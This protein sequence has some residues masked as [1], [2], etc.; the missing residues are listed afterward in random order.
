MQVYDEN[1]IFT[2]K[3]FLVKNIKEIVLIL[4]F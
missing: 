4:A 3:L 1:N 2:I